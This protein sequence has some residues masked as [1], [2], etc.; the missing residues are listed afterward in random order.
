VLGQSIARLREGIDLASAHDLVETAMRGFHNLSVSLHATGSSGA[1][2]RRVKEEMFAYARRHRFRS[3]VLIS[4]EALYVFADGDW[5]AVLELVREPRGE[6]VWSIQHRLLEAFIVAGRA[7]PERALPLLEAPR[8]ALRELSPSH[9]IFGASLLGRVALLAGDARATLEDLDGIAADVGRLSYPE[10]DEAAVCAL[11]AAMTQED[12]IALDRWIDV[13]LAD[14]GGARRVSAHARRAF[15]Q[16]E[17]AAKEGDLDLA[18]SL[19]AE[20]AESF[21]QSFL[22]FGETLAR[23]RRIELLLGQDGAG[24]RDAAQAELAA[25]VPYWRKAKATWYLG[26]LERWAADHG[27]VFSRGGFRADSIV[28]SP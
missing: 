6:S 20:S 9:T 17:R 24:D 21:S 1:E 13:A 16:A 27:L 12:I 14:E 18:T 23:R 7:G 26:Q 5:D 15:A 4:D 2:T 19:L 22:P 28:T 8:R 11:T 3:D 10:V 25:V